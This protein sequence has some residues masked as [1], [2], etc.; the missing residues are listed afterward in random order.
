MSRKELRQPDKVLSTMERGLEVASTH[1]RVLLIGSVVVVVAVGLFIFYHLRTKAK[2]EEGGKLFQRGLRT[3]TAGVDPSV[4]PGVK[5]QKGEEVQAFRTVQDRAQAALV[6]FDQ[7]VR[8]YEG[9]A[10]ARSAHFYRGRCLY[11]LKKYGDA[12]SAFKKVLS[13][14]SGGCGGGSMPG[15]GALEALALENLG[16]AQ[17]A[18]GRMEDAR[19]TFAKLREMDK[20]NRRDWGYYHE[21]LLLEAKGDLAGAIKAYDK[22]KQSG[23]SSKGQDPNLAFAQSPL[24]E[25]SAKRAR[26]LQ[27]KLETK[28]PEA[29]PRKARPAGDDMAP[30]GDDKAPAG[31]DKAPA[32]DDKAPAGD[33]MAPAGDDMAPAGDDMAPR[34]A[35][36]AP[37]GGEMAP[38][39]AAMAPAGGEMAPG[40]AAMAPAGGEMAPGP[41]A[42][43]PADMAAAN[44]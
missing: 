38:G 31:D 3:F 37:A 21:A 42:M 35:A 39:P 30:A 10:V 15:S 18:K 22:I 9:Y 32:G 43:A 40:P 20:G 23:Q 4:S 36:M 14:K 11:D 27:M 2:A 16:Y 17:L 19:S 7:V 6:L 41:A 26:Y 8:D 28:E 12:I 29:T 44:P 25:L 33:D 5:P 13:T 1:R 34:P 24:A